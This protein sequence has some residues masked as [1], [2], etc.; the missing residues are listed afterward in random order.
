MITIV[1][2][3]AGN[4]R[5]IERALAHFGEAPVITSDPERLSRAGAIV[6]PGVG[7]AKAAMQQLRSTGVA[8][9][10][11]DAANTGT[12]IIGICLGMQLLFGDQE[13]GPTTGLALFEGTGARLPNLL[14][15][16]H[17]GWNS[18][19]FTD[20]GP[21][22]GT[23]DATVYFVHSYVVQPTDSVDIA[24]ETE[25]GITFPSVVARNNIWG[26]QFHPEKS[27]VVGLS[28]LRRWLDVARS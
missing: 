6:F 28:L 2:Y 12:P 20:T 17:M 7:N 22:A 14:K 16:P 13:E 26:T 11:T 15:V 25:Y 27:G 4:L 9:A 23:P 3:G 5:S 19:R 10:I 18:V 21:M 8:D 24:A 1:D